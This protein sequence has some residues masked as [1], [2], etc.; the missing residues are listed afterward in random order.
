MVIESRTTLAVASSSPV[1]D[2]PNISETGSTNGVS[3]AP[4]NPKRAM[5][6]HPIA[7]LNEMRCCLASTAVNSNKTRP[8]KAMRRA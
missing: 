2:I 6:V 4:T 5:S 8:P 3:S 7:Y 1:G